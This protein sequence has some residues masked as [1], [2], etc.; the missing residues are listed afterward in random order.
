MDG[1][2]CLPDDLSI[3]TQLLEEINSSGVEL[4]ELWKSWH[5]DSHLIADDHTN[6]KKHCPTFNMVLEKMAD[7]F[8][9]KVA[10]TRFNWYRNSSE[11]K[12][13]HHDAAAIKEDKGPA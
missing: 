4:D 13:F 10:A 7:Y 11:W 8:K 3:Y 1:L 9:M 2:F 6:W 5:Q 12:P